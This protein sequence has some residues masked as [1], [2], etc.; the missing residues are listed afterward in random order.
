MTSD[1]IGQTTMEFHICQFPHMDHFNRSQ[2]QH[3]MG[4]RD[5]GGPL[6]GG[7]IQ[8]VKARGVK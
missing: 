6:G 2:G 4:C 3:N 8:K 5:V 1:R 7:E